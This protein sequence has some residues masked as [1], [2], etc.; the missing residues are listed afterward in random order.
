MGMWIDM[1]ARIAMM[2]VAVETM[3]EAMI[4]GQAVAGR[5]FGRGHQRDQKYKGRGDDYEDS[6]GRQDDQ[7]GMMVQV[8]PPTDSS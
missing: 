6:Y 3:T 8:L 7:R 4:T 1:G 2:T 5:V